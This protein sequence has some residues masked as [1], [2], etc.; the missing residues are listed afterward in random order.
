MT[1]MTS[2]RRSLAPD[3][4]RGFMLLAIALAHAPVF[5]SGAGPGVLNGVA[6]FLDHLLAH[7]QARP[8]FVFLFGYALGQLACR[9]QAKGVDWI[10]LRKLLRRRGRWLIV[11]GFVHGVLLVP[12]DIVAVYGLTLLVLA[13]LVRA[14]DS[15]LCWTAALAL[16]P[17]ALVVSGPII[18][19]YAGTVPITP[20]GAMPA[21]LG[22]HLLSGLQLWPFKTVLGTIDVVPG[23]LLG[24]W[25]ARRRI[26][27][28][29]ERHKSLLR[30]VTVI[31]LGVAF[32]SRL[33]GALLMAGVWTPPA[34]SAAV[35]AHTLTGYA[36]GIALAALIGLVATRVEGGPF[37]TALAALGQR[38]LTFYLFQSVVFL[39]LFYPFTLDL[40]GDLGFAD[41]AGLAVAIWAVS[42]LLA[43]WMRRAGYRGP[44]EAMLRRLTYRRSSGA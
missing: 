28:E 9:H 4:A 1:V 6:A 16:V 21:D 26:L 33:P 24:I 12:L 37:T 8:M 38:S 29:P 20:A 40:G 3:L 25:A 17:A 36:G 31:G 13:P 19:A 18:L 23:M 34:P 14:R 42:I 27:D 30:R 22:S 44:A 7:N 32:I 11:I 35:L 5:V 39:V 2:T 41:A 10:S 15:V 43:E